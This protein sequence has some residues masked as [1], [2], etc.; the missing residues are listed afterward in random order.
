MMAV[1]AAHTMIK[2]HRRSN[3]RMMKIGRKM[4]SIDHRLITMLLTVW[5]L[6]CF[7]MTDRERFG[8]PP[9]SP[10]PPEVVTFDGYVDPSGEGCS[11]FLVCVS[12]NRPGS[13]W[14]GWGRGVE[15]LRR[16][17]LIG[18]TIIKSFAIRGT[19]NPLGIR[20][21]LYTKVSTKVEI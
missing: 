17:V 19:L 3:L 7:A 4:V 13:V 10:V 5:G 20:Y 8:Q 15:I 16:F 14:E 9:L 2:S 18:M 11:N 12:R 21:D 1:S 6:S